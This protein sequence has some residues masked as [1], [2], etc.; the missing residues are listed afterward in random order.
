M[1]NA[2]AASIF[3]DDFIFDNVNPRSE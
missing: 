2:T 3:A 1:H